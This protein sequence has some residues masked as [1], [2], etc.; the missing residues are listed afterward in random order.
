MSLSHGVL[1]AAMAF[2]IATGIILIYEGIRYIQMKK[3]NPSFPNTMYVAASLSI[4]VG[5]VDIAFGVA[6]FW[7]LPKSQSQ[8]QPVSR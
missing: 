5:V 4:I 3:K 6:H 2:V 7:F 8:P 1:Y